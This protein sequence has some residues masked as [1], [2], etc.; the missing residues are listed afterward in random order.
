MGMVNGSIMMF[1][2]HANPFFFSL[3]K[4]YGMHGRFWEFLP[5]KAGHSLFFLAEGFGSQL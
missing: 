1:F 5:W 2:F 3:G 4:F